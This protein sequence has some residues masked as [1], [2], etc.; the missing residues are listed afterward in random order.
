[1]NSGR[2]QNHLKGRVVLVTGANGALGSVAAKAAAG[3]GATVV[4]LGRSIPRLERLYDEIIAGGGP[5]PAIYPLDLA[6]AKDTDYNDLA[7]SI[8]S[9][10][11]GLHGLFHGAAELGFLEPAAGIGFPR[12]MRV[13]HVNLTAPF[14]LTSTLLPLLESAEKAS[15][16]F[17]GDSGVGD[18]NAFWG[19]YGVAKQGLKAYSSILAS[20]KDVKRLVVNYF[21]PGP[22]RTPIRLAAFP[23]ENLQELPLAEIHAEH[24]VHL[25][26]AGLQE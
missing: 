7:L 13:M 22:M 10:F 11:G 17:T 25:L 2:L 12:W 6:G 3:A 18:G 21:V 16:V 15:I 26:A 24:I 4:L 9:E 23:A 1:M 5:E 14:M 8:Q 19:A 20:E